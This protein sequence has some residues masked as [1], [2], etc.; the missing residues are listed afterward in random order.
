MTIGT[1]LGAVPTTCWSASK[2]AANTSWAVVS[3]STRCLRDKRRDQRTEA[4]PMIEDPAVKRVFVNRLLRAKNVSGW[5]FC[6]IADLCGIT[7]GYCTQLFRGQARLRP[8]LAVNLRKAVPSLTDDDIE[9]MSRDQLWTNNP[10][11]RQQPR[12]NRKPRLVFTH[13]VYL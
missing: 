10:I 12:D 13:I 7:R 9:A 4:E 2:M 6:K 8:E 3:D 1:S 11:V 5:T